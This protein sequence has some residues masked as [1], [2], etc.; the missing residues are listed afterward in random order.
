MGKARQIMGEGKA[1]YGQG[2]LASPIGL[3]FLSDSVTGRAAHRR[4]GTTELCRT[5][6]FAG[7]ST[8]LSRRVTRYQKIS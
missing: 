2:L 5:F 3:V 6:S 7:L 1:G 8:T 4:K